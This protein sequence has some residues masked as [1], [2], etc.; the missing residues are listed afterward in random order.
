MRTPRFFVAFAVSFL[1][2]GFIG[3]YSAV[4]SDT[5]DEVLV[6]TNT[7]IGACATV[8]A[9]TEN[10][11]NHRAQTSVTGRNLISIGCITEVKA[12]PSGYLGSNAALIRTN[13]MACSS[14]GTTYSS[15]TTA[16]KSSSALW[17]S[18]ACGNGQSLSAT[19]YGYFYNGSGY[20]W[21]YIQAAYQT[22][23]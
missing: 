14:V 20:S 4:A 18:G 10:I 9:L 15:S 12:V 21:K 11:S 22:F 7:S 1:A 16:Y 23:P 3:G 2:A 8:R 6:G 17:S 5:S 13:G 19:G